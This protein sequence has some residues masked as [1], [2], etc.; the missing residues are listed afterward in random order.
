MTF[1]SE[2]EQVIIQLYEAGHPTQYIAETTKYACRSSIGAWLRSRGLIRGLIQVKAKRA[3]RREGTR[4]GRLIMLER[5]VTG[6]GVCVWKCLCDCGTTKVIRND[7]LKG[8]KGTRSCGCLLRERT[9]AVGKSN[10][11]WRGYEELPSGLFNNYRT[12]AQ[13]KGIVFDMSIEGAWKLFETQKRRCALTGLLLV[14]P[15]KANAS[16][17]TA[18]LDRIDP[19]R[20]YTEDNVQWVHKWINILKA[21]LSDNDLLTIVKAIY[22]HR[23]LHEISL[24]EDQLRHAVN[25]VPFPKRKLHK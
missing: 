18:S 13:L 22:E 10:R 11:F 9:H 5:S 17:G 20:G 4:Q 16:D 21:G 12:N 2:Q 6:D 3:K 7:A 15:S 24:S 14:F 1:T 23:R 8:I 25:Y 19:V